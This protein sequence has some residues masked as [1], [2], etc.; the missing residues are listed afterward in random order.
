MDGGKIVDAEIL[1]DLT[2]HQVDT[3]YRY[4]RIDNKWYTLY[5]VQG[6]FYLMK[7]LD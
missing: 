3:M 1:P 4:H 2:R 5:F 6:Y 7:D